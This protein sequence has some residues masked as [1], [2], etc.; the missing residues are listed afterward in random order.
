MFDE[1]TSLESLKLQWE[2]FYSTWKSSRE[3]R[4]WKVFGSGIDSSETFSFPLMNYGESEKPGNCVQFNHVEIDWFTNHVTEFA[5]IELARAKFASYIISKTSGFSSN[6]FW[7]WSEKRKVRLKWRNEVNWNQICEKKHFKGN[8]RM[9][10]RLA[11]RNFSESCRN[12]I[13]EK[14]A[15]ELHLKF[16][17]LRDD[18]WS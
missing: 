4:S 14:I 18:R 1:N 13:T 12:Y 8:V 15:V 5:N 2:S 17:F 16:T 6:S 9:W 7:F 10:F 3:K 11:K